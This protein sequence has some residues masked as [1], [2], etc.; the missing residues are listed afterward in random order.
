MVIS[1]T[2][3]KN[4]YLDVIMLILSALVV[5]YVIFPFVGI[6]NFLEPSKLL[7]SFVR[8]QLDNAF[9]LSLISSTISTLILIFLGIPLA[10]CLARYDF[11]GKFFL[12]TIVIF[13]LVLPPLASGA[14][15]L[16]VFSP[17]SI[18]GS[19][20]PVIDFTQ[21][22]IGII[23]A[24]TYVASPFM[25]LTCQAAFE[26]VDRSYE[27]T[28]R[29]LGKNKIDTFFKVTLPLAKAGIIT[30]ILLTWVRS[31]G[32]LGA[33]M[34][35]SYNPHTIS[36]QIFEDNAIGDLRQAI[37]DIILVILL[38][39]VMLVAISILKKKNKNSLKIEWN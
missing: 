32:E 13:P 11:R 28:S 14:L 19:Y 6:L 9:I 2:D 30:G 35:M 18:L 4:Q 16:G 36:I 15:L 1:F 37:P 22:L 10:Y 25:I 29:V 3:I 7:E 17:S 24:Q 5:A 33:T 34:M 20:F 8:P 39:I 38:S 26:A 27:L 12:Q 31:I 21:S 23:I